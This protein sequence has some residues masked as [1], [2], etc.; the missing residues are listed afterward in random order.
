[1]IAAR[2]GRLRERMA[3]AGLDAVIVGPSADYRWLTD[4]H[5]PIPTRLTL[6]IVPLHGDPVI[7]TPGFEAPAVAGCE[8]VPLERRHRC[9]R[10]RR[11]ISC[12]G[13]APRRVAV[14]DQ[15]WARYALA[16]A[17]RDSAPSSWPPVRCSSSCAR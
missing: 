16:A 13:A 17:G 7:V 6:A 9:A 3:V 8:V 4:L 12:G 1:M 14:S 11:P 2:L 10:A 15:T 5:P